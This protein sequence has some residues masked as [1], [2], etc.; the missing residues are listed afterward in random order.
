[1]FYRRKIILALIEVFGRELDNTD[2][3][4]LLFLFCKKYDQNF[5]DFFPYKF[6]CFS[7]VS[8][9]DKRI[10]T[11]LGFLDNVEKFKLSSRTN[12]LNEIKSQDKKNLISFAKKMKQIKG[13]NLVRNIYTEFP[14]YA[15][16][17]EIIKEVFTE[18]E[19]D[20]II[21][22]ASNYKK[23]NETTLF[24][25]GYEGLTIDAY[26]NKLIKNNIRLVIDVRK[27]PRS[28]KFDFNQNKLKK[29]LI[30]VDI[31]YLHLPELGIEPDLRKNLHSIS[32]YEKLLEFYK[33]T[34]L[35]KNEKSLILIFEN[36][37]KYN[38]ISLLCFEKQFKIC[39]RS[40]IAEN[41]EK[42][43]N[44]KVKHIN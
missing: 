26:L 13:K 18:K 8:Y 40:K 31:D 35:I 30:S 24:T 22:K 6:G 15:S 25:L 4:K 43:N 12:F 20:E 10:L 39:H 7:Y 19:L 9:Q 23:Q 33:R 38:R 28:M 42:R 27:N 11:K 5:Y 3:E 16:R 14:Y 29:Y 2:F 1:M 37:K 17:S 44:I 21:D 32:D 36:L 41:L 34:L